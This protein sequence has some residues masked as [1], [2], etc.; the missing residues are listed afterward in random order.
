[1]KKEKI[2]LA[3]LSLVMIA[4]SMLS[5]NM[6]IEH[7]QGQEVVERIDAAEAKKG[8]GSSKDTK[9]AGITEKPFQV[10]V[11]GMD[12]TGSLKQNRP[13]R[14]DSNLLLTVNP[15][16]KKI[17]I[18]NLPREI[19][20]KP[21][22]VPEFSEKDAENMKL[23]GMTEDQIKEAKEARKN[24]MKTKLCHVSLYGMPSLVKTVEGVL[25]TKIDY[26]IQLTMTGFKTLVDA[27]G[28]VD[29]EAVESFETDWGT[30]YQKGINH[31]NGKEAVAFVRERHHFND[32]ALGRGT[33]NVEMMRAIIHKLCDA[34]LLDMDA[35]GL[36]QLWKNNVETDMGMGEVLS[37]LRMQVED[38]AEWKITTVIVKGEG[39]LEKTMEYPGIKLFVLIPDPASVKEAQEKIADVCK[40]DQ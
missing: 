1:M 18:T 35:D 39:S 23:S 31:V 34:S 20:V 29:V 3:V 30:S 6:L 17:L 26:H 25:D 9:K 38:R 15:V 27:I 21:V 5:L 12:I 4:G 37:L 10:L 16:D 19:Y 24:G 22:D 7:I 2:I 40:V 36:Y 13:Y 14:N 28:G 8:K 32:G 11:S 33:N